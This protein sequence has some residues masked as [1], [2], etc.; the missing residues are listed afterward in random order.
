MLLIISIMLFE[1]ATADAAPGLNSLN[2]CQRR[3]SGLETQ[4]LL[5]L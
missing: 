5:T 2:S 3:G 4:K 1:I